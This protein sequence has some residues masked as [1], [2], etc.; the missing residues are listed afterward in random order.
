MFTQDA[1]ASTGQLWGI[2]K[3]A[4]LSTVWDTLLPAYTVDCV[5]CSR[6]S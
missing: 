4:I 5:Q 3:N 2:N 1:W 6:A